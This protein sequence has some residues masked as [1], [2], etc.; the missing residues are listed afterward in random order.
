MNYDKFLGVYQIG[1]FKP[2][3]GKNLAI[4]ALGIGPNFGP[5]NGLEKSLSENT[6]GEVSIILMEQEAQRA[7]YR[8]PEYNVPRFWR[9]MPGRPF[10]LID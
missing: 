7:T 8:A 6:D 3:L 9:N 5:Q 10:F 4:F 2:F 1:N